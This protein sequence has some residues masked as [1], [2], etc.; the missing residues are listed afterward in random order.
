M[1]LVARYVIPELQGALVPQQASA[2]F[3]EAH[4]QELMAGASRAVMSKILGTSVP[5]WRWP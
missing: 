2:D 1:D 3:V 4:K 5:P